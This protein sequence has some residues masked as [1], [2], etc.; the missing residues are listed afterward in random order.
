MAGTVALV[1]AQEQPRVVPVRRRSAEGL[2]IADRHGSNRAGTAD[3]ECGGTVAEHHA[4]A[5]A[6]RLNDAAKVGAALDDDHSFAGAIGKQESIVAE[7]LRE[8]L[9][10]GPRAPYARGA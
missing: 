1:S 8:G 2:R 6:V 10:L 9:R 5:G 7:G 4:V 3:V